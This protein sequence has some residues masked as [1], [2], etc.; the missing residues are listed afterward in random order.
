MIIIPYVS[1]VTYVVIALLTA[2]FGFNGA[3]CVSLYEN[4]IEFAPNYV[5][6]VN[7]IANALSTTAGLI[8][9]FIV[10]ALTSERVI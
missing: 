10:T 1:N 6:T 3:I 7:S 5:S 9:P 4:S 8:S 2:S